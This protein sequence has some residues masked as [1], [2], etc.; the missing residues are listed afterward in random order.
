MELDIERPERS[1]DAVS[2]IH[3]ER[4]RLETLDALLDELQDVYADAVTQ[5]EIDS[6]GSVYHRMKELR[7]LL[8]GVG[9]DLK[10]MGCFDDPEPAMYKADVERVMYAGHRLYLAIYGRLVFIKGAKT[11]ANERAM[12]LEDIDVIE[13]A[14]PT[15]EQLERIERNRQHLQKAIEWKMG[16]IERARALRNKGK[17]RQ[18]KRVA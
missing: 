10:E 5:E 13:A 12:L 14:V 9:L 11:L 15:T 1:V 4:E 17:T 2:V 6:T 3:V 18:I 16:Q 8:D 7:E